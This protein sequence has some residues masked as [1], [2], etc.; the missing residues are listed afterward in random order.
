MMP[1]TDEFSHTPRNAKR[2]AA[3]QQAPW[4]QAC[5]QGWRALLL[6]IKAKLEAVES[7]ITTLESEFLANV[8]LPDGGTVGQWLAHQVE[9][10]YAT[11]K[12]S[13]MLGAESSP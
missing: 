2:T 5:R 4:E 3:A 10:A 12:M 7:G 8:V 1:S 13:R 6:I 11:G 9:E